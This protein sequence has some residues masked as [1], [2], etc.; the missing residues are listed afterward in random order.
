MRPETFLLKDAKVHE[1]TA[2]RKETAAALTDAGRHA[3]S[4]GRLTAENA[5]LK[6]RTEEM[7]S[8]INALEGRCSKLAARLGAEEEKNWELQRMLDDALSVKPEIKICGNIA[9]EMQQPSDIVQ[10]SDRGAP[11]FFR[12]FGGT[13]F[14]SFMLTADRYI[15]LI[16]PGLATMVLK[17][18]ENGRGVECREN[19][20]E[21]PGIGSFI[22]FEEDRDLRAEINPDGRITVFVD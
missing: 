15:P 12:W 14:S 2:C 9:E 20:I 17:P 10:E 18:A 5:A 8:E 22:R 21:I 19:T 6:K 1:T 7:R 13:R 3:W 4:D 11:G 16:G